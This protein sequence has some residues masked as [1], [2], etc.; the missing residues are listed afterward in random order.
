M[1]IDDD[2]FT[3]LRDKDHIWALFKATGLL[4]DREHSLLPRLEAPASAPSRRST[5]ARNPKAMAYQA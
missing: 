1:G 4:W 2:E 3:N 5:P